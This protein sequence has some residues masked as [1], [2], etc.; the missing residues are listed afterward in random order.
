[1]KI[2]RSRT[3]ER[4]INFTEALRDVSRGLTGAYSVPDDF[5]AQS[6]SIARLENGISINSA[7]EF[8]D[9]VHYDPDKAAGIAEEFTK[10][11]KL[12]DIG[13]TI[14]A[15]EFLRLG[16]DSRVDGRSR[17]IA[18]L[19]LRAARLELLLSPNGIPEVYATAQTQTHNALSL[20]ERAARLAYEWSPSWGRLTVDNALNQA[21]GAV[22]KQ[23]IAQA[24]MV[25]VLALAGCGPITV[26][27]GTPEITTGQGPTPTSSEVV[28]AMTG[29]LA[30]TLKAT[31]EPTQTGEI[32]C[33]V[34]AQSE[35]FNKG[36]TDDSRTVPVLSGAGFT[37]VFGADVPLLGITNKIANDVAGL[38]RTAP[39]GIT[40]VIIPEGIRPEDVTSGVLQL[41]GS[42]QMPFELA[43]YENGMVLGKNDVVVAVHAGK[44]GWTTGVWKEASLTQDET[45]RN[46]INGLLLESVGGI[47]YVIP[48]Q[49]IDNGRVVIVIVDGCGPSIVRAEGNTV[50]AILNPTADIV[51]DL[52]HVWV[53]NPGIAT[54]ESTQTI[55]PTENLAPTP[56][57]TAIVF[58]TS[59][60]E[61]ITAADGKQYEGF[62]IDDHY[63]TRLVDSTNNIIL[64]KDG[65][66]W[67][68]PKSLNYSPEYPAVFY[69]TKI[70]NAD[71]FKIPIT[72]GLSANVSKGKGF[73]YTEAHM[74]QLGADD[75]ASLY[76]KIAWTRYRDIMNHPGT[77]YEQYLGLLR[78]GKGNIEIVDAKT[79]SRVLVDPRQGFSVV[80]T[81]DETHNMPLSIYDLN[82]FYFS[83]DEKGKLL[84]VNNTANL[85]RYYISDK[86][87]TT[88]N[89]RG[90]VFKSVADVF[91][92]AALPD[93]CMIDRV[94]KVCGKPTVPDLYVLDPKFMG[95]YDAFTFNKSNDPLFT[96]R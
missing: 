69:E 34:D 73:I 36:I 2:E 14:G 27:F 60:P 49:G 46:Q 85:Y 28:P 4:Y 6:A 74:T 63:G 51:N 65:D 9:H 37:E 61:T 70:G 38:V 18:E 62:L 33:S 56:E 47:Y 15:E 39:E 42:A 41:T 95:D 5:Y 10:S 96:L 77:S 16:P 72:L 1:M 66:T 80:I 31:L 53:I 79:K 13:V 20:V 17:T 3:A 52:E 57:G 67:R 23:K 44:G 48:A 55:T 11:R 8:L 71:G 78:Q 91:W 94:E 22:S 86:Y 82:G 21:R 19:A 64:V 40:R 35:L 88:E 50:T 93:K 68:V 87:S 75:T 24:S 7:K 25:G 90:F 12:A 43:T 45:G 29:T 54:V 81:G 84:F 32:T 59:R 83:S 76:L 58:D 92:I 26:S 30:P 89:N